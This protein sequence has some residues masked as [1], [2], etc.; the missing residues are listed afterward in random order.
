MGLDPGA[1]GAVH[2]TRA[3][4][5]PADA[6]TPVGD[7]GGS[8]PGTTALDTADGEDQPSALLA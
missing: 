3:E 1:T 4:E 8:C 7:P 2:V 6:D 5:S